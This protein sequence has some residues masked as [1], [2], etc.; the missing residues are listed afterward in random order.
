MFY[1]A[2]GM[3]APTGQGADFYVEYYDLGIADWVTAYEIALVPG[4]WALYTWQ[5]QVSFRS[6][7]YGKN[8]SAVHFVDKYRRHATYFTQSG[9]YPLR[10]GWDFGNDIQGVT[11]DSNNWYMSRTNYLFGKYGELI[12]IG[13]GTD[14]GNEQGG[15]VTQ[16]SEWLRLYDHYG[17]LS[18][19]NGNLMVA[20]DGPAGCAVGVFRT[21]NLSLVGFK[22]LSTAGGCGWLAYNPRDRVYYTGLPGGGS[23]LLGRFSISVLNNEITTSQ[24]SN[25]LLTSSVSGIQGGEFSARG[26]LWV[27]VGINTLPLHLYAIDPNNGFIYHRA[28]FN[29]TGTPSDW[30]AE[31]ITVWDLT[32]GGAPNIGGHLH[33][34]VLDNDDWSKDQFT[35]WH[36]KADTPAAL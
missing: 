13:K 36:L 31:G 12:K 25:L 30:E 17:D 9:Q 29:G 10:Q 18:L 32:G 14:L 24:N 22:K 4:Q 15:E 20:A 11:H 28:A 26:V 34:Q 21:T 16:P 19:V 1:Q 5:G 3:S 23:N 6:M 7:I 35:F 8:Q 27:W 33:L 2:G